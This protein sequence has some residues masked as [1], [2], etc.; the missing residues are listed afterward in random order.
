MRLRTLEP[1]WLIKN[2]L[3][4]TYPS[5][6]KNETS[7]IVVVGAG[8]TGALVSHALIQNNYDVILLDKR[9]VGMGSTSA[10]TGMLQY[11]ID[12]PL[13]KLVEQIGEEGAIKCYRAGIKALDDLRDLIIHNNIDCDFEQKQSLYISRNESEARWL[14][15]EFEMRDKFNLRVKWLDK[16]DVFDLYG[17]CCFG[18]ILSQHAASVDAYRLCHRLI[19]LNVNKGLKVYDQTEI[20]GFN[21]RN[22]PVTI[23]AANG[24]RISCGKI[25][26]CNGYEA[27][28]MLKEKVCKLFYTY[29]SISEQDVF[30]KEN[31][32]NTLVWD[33]GSP[34]SYLRTTG[35]NRILIGGADSSFN[36]PFFENKIKEIKMKQ[37]QNRLKTIIPSV[38]FIEDFSWGGTFGSTKDGLPYIGESPEYKNALFVLGFGG[39]GIIFSVQAMEIISELLKGKTHELLSWYRFNR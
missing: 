8:I 14:N 12:V 24:C 15:M 1:Y 2:G 31:L 32:K 7:Q 37:L 25:I 21:L 30:F 17:I 5:L 34:Y 28:K 22:S 10:T 26:F 39:N 36:V 4:S 38:N 16:K 29:A 3:L 19:E 20:K 27:T 9:D 33:T 35:D 13:Y 11:E 23:H 18:A 6:Q